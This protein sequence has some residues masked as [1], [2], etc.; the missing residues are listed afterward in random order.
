MYI[1]FSFLYTS[2]CLFF[3]FIII[4]GKQYKYKEEPEKKVCE[5]D[6]LKHAANTDFV[7][8]TKL[9]DYSQILDYT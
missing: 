2:I 9:I 1:Y 7:R 3:N 4:K 6:V 8:F 5:F